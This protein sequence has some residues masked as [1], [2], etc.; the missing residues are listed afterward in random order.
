MYRVA[1]IPYFLFFIL[2][3]STVPS[4]FLQAKGFKI[5]FYIPEYCLEAILIKFLYLFLLLNYTLERITFVSISPKT[6]KFNYAV[7]IITNIVITV[8]SLLSAVPNFEEIL[9]E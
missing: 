1:R 7:L 8:S 5:Y 9:W 4:L 3:L 2:T 6:D